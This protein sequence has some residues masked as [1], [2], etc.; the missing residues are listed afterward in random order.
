MR[1]ASVLGSTAF[2]LMTTFGAVLLAQDG[3]AL[4]GKVVGPTGQALA[5][6]LVKARIGGMTVTVPSQL[7]GS[8]RMSGLRS[9]VYEVRAERRGLMA[10]AQRVTVPATGPV[11][12]ELEPGPV[13]RYNLSTRDLETVLPD[14]PHRQTLLGCEICHSWSGLAAA[15]RPYQQQF[16]INGMRLMIDKGFTRINPVDIPAMAEYLHAN[17]GRDARLPLD[18]L[19]PDPLD[20]HGLNIRYVTFD[21]PTPNA[22]P[23]TAAPDG[24]GN[25]WFAEFGGRRIGVVNVT[26]G[27]ME[28]FDITHHSLPRAHGLTV[29]PFGNVWFTEQGAGTIGRFDPRT[30]TMSHYRI[31]P[32]K[33]PVTLP[34][35]TQAPSDRNA[36]PHTLISD[37]RG[38]IWFTAGNHPVRK[39]NT[40][41]GEFTEYVIREGGGGLYGITRDPRNGRIWYAGLGINEVGYIDPATGNVTR[42]TMLTPD[43]GPR[44]LHL[45]STGVAWCNLY[46]VSKIA[47][48]DP[49]TGT[50][51]EWDLPGGRDGNPYAFGVDHRDRLW[52]STY[53]DD[54]LHMFDPKTERFTT[55]LMPS[56]GNGL[57]DFFLD[58][59]GWLWAGVFGRNQVIGFTLEDES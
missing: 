49:A 21:I 29:D 23:H 34:A 38:D 43:A 42:F 20:E 46:N 24:R 9:G 25:V 4:S 48:I 5:G 40:E 13:D 36:S 55:Y 59:K 16:W 7:D 45:D 8:Y 1:K 54:R 30:K 10:A 14:S 32:L 22:M 11:S 12:F 33:N 35:G 6:V 57:R 39:L 2:A 18:Q 19:P 58:E 51:T 37:A 15:R 28:E 47:R 53:R 31:P 26:T 50:V 41:T 17:F 27:E 52:T 56:K 3:P 44:R